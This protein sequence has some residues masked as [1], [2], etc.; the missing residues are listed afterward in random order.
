MNEGIKVSV[1]PIPIS[2]VVHSEFCARRVWLESVGEKTDTMQIQAG[3][4]AHRSL[5]RKSV[6]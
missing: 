1:D 3:L 2:L 6:V 4:D 5:D